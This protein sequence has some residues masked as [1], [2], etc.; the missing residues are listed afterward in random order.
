MDTL[1]RL[2]TLINLAKSDG[3]L[4]EEERQ[5]IL[6]IGQANHYMV[7]EILPLFSADDFAPKLV[8]RSAD[9]KAGLL[10][11]V[12]Q[13][14]QID[15]KI[16]KAEIRYCAHVVARLGYRE[17]VVFELMLQAHDLKPG[18]MEGL[19]KVMVGYMKK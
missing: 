14:M 8:A 5:H 16:F 2:K 17:E 12:V 1:G 9:E 3:S 7:A 4:A 15:D 13:L 6:A 19:R 11:E 18:D 10:L